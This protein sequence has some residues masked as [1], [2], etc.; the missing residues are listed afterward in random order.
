[1]GAMSAAHVGAGTAV[2]GAQEVL[3][4]L[5]DGRYQSSHAECMEEIRQAIN[6]VTTLAQ[7][8]GEVK[9]R[10]PWWA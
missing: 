5:R 2:P 3:A 4:L 10:K 9:E 6:Y 1:M 8:T 7:E